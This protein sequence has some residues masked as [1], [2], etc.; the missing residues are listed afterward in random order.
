MS[1]CRTLEVSGRSYET[2][3]EEQFIRAGLIAGSQMMTP[4]SSKGRRPNV[5]LYQHLG[6]H[7]V[8]VKP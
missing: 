3:P 5:M 4:P 6:S 1:D 2:I 8:C 7:A